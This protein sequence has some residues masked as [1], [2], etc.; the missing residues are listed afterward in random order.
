MSPGTIITG[1]VNGHYSVIIV[2]GDDNGTIYIESEE[3][4]ILQ[5][6]AMQGEVSPEE[7]FL[8]GHYMQQNEAWRCF[9]GSVLKWCIYRFDL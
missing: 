8:R 6:Y 1:I 3:E 2:L 9:G 4:L 5:C 7:G